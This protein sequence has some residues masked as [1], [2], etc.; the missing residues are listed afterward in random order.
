MIYRLAHSP[1]CPSE[2]KAKRSNRHFCFRF[3][4]RSASIRNVT[5]NQFCRNWY[6]GRRGRV[7]QGAKAAPRGPYAAHT[8]PRVTVGDC[9]QVLEGCLLSPRGPRAADTRCR[10]FRGRRAG[11]ARGKR[12]EEGV[13]ASGGE[14]GVRCGERAYRERGCCVERNV[15]PVYKASGRKLTWVFKQ[16]KN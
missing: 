4:I 3:I 16:R 12:C 10:P 1:G 8:F 9:S 14:G 13:C 11:L 5:V 2:S 7:R 15:S 6:G